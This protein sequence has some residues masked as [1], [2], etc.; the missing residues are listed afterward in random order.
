MTEEHRAKMLKID[1]QILVAESYN[2]AMKK[3][4]KANDAGPHSGGVG[5]TASEATTLYRMMVE[6]AGMREFVE[7][8]RRLEAVG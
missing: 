5:L 4:R 1:Q 6:C 7:V 3:L 8:P 2:S